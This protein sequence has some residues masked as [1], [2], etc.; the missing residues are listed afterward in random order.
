MVGFRLCAGRAVAELQLDVLEGGEATRAVRVLR[1]V[2][3]L[4]R[5]DHAG[6]RGRS[7]SSGAMRSP[8]QSRTSA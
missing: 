8:G 3:E 7:P 5:A 2:G 6:F 1:N 4:G